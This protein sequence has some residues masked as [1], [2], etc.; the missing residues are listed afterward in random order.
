MP[1][2]S[3]LSTSLYASI[4]VWPAI[5]AANKLLYILLR[6]SSEYEAGIIKFSL[7][8]HAATGTPLLSFNLTI[9]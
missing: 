4:T 5:F 1:Q 8:L 7:L 3:Q 6:D 9:I 2:V